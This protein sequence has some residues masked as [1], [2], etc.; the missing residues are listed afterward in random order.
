[1]M[2]VAWELKVVVLV[3]VSDVASLFSQLLCFLWIGKQT[4]KN[5]FVI[6]KDSCD[7]VS[8]NRIQDVI[9]EL[10]YPHR[11]G[12]KERGKNKEESES[13]EETCRNRSEEKGQ[14]GGIHEEGGECNIADPVFIE[15]TFLF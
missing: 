9:F 8:L 4:F 2:N 1:M 3:V 10:H 12:K 13:K 14:R 5:E 7:Q 11:G 15:I 6:W